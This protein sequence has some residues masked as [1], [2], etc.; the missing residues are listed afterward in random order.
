MIDESNP[1]KK[2]KI[3]SGLETIFREDLVSLLR[4]YAD[5]FVWIPR[6]M[7]GLHESIAMHS[8]D[9]NPNRK[10]VKQKRRNF[11]PERQRA[12]DEEVEK[13]LKDGIICKVKYLEWLAN[14]VM[15]KKVN[16]K[17]RMYIDYTDLNS[18]CPKDPYP[19]QIL[20]N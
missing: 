7:S 19:C 5:I 10:P 2:V 1:S 6:D 11:A 8:V 4:S 18:A 20:I 15:V 13:L 3:R 16:G 12:I 17:W 9:V 14:V